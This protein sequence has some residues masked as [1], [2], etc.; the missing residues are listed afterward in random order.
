MKIYIYLCVQCTL[1][2]FL[3][4]SLK[5][6]HTN[7]SASAGRLGAETGDD[8]ARAPQSAQRARGTAEV[9]GHSAGAA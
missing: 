7:D 8:V 1:R 5:P 6:G 3:C 2:H 4:S 9:E